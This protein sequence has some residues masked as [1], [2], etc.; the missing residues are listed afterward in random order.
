M[1]C[2]V[3]SQHDPKQNG[4]IGPVLLVT[5]WYPPTIGGV[6]LVAERLQ[7][8]LSGAGVPTVVWIC[9]SDPDVRS[10]TMQAVPHVFY[11]WIPSTVFYGLTVRSLIGAL[12][13]FPASL[14]HAYSVVRKHTVRTVVLLYPIG[15]A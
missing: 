12:L 13:R 10:K 9:D 15:Y 7:R 11:K 14:W 3:L 8:L 5:P 2:A 4:D 1:G 6:S